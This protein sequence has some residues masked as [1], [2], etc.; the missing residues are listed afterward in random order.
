MI[1]DSSNKNIKFAEEELDYHAIYNLGVFFND[2]GYTF[3]TKKHRNNPLE[4][5]ITKVANDILGVT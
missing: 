3:D 2:D 1:N 4:L 5:P